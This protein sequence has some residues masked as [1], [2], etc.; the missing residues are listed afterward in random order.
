MKKLA[1]IRE[2]LE[3]LIMKAETAEQMKAL[4]RLMKEIDT[5]VALFPAE[6]EVEGKRR[7]RKPKAQ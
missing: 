1:K 2:D 7:G 5:V 4:F 6:P 3:Q